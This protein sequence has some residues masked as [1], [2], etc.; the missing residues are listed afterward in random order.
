VGT[1]CNNYY[2]YP[3]NTGVCSAATITVSPDG[4]TVTFVPSANLAPSQ[5]HSLNASSATDL[6]G[7]AQQNFGVGF[8]TTAGTDTTAPT[9]LTSNPANGATGAPLNSSIEVQFSEAVSNTTLTQI[10]LMNGATPVPF[11]ASL[12][13]SDSTIHLTPAS[14]L[15]ANTTY[16][17]SVK[18]VTDVAGNTMVGTYTFSFTTGPNV[19]ENATPNVVSVVAN[20]LPLTNNV[21]VNNVPDNPTFTITLDTPVEPASLSAG[22]LVLYLNSNTNITYPL[23]IALSA[24]QKTITVT[25]APGTLAAATEYQFRVGY[26]YRIRDWAGNYNGGQYYIY[27]FTTQ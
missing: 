20:G 7:N 15:V 9:V 14:L 19:D 3:T 8:T 21:N 12:I 22:A 1:T 24:D 10:T 11:T 5:G 4:T 18:G 13:Y 6:N 23:N 16:T 26:N 2:F 17:V 27:Y 25:L